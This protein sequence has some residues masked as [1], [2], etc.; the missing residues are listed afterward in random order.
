MWICGCGGSHGNVVVASLRF[1]GS[2]GDMVV[3]ACGCGHIF[4]DEKI[5]NLVF[6]L[7]LQIYNNQV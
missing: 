5:Q 2:Y 4:V 3:P 1:F 6:R 7:I